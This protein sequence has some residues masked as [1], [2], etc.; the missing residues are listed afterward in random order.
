ME[1]SVLTVDDSMSIREAVRSVLE[2]LGCKILEAEDGEQGLAR[3][4]RE[5][6]DLVI[7]DLDMPNIDGIEFIKRVRCQDHLRDL[8][9]LMLTTVGQAERMRDGKSA[10]ASG[11]IVKPFNELQLELAVMKFF[12]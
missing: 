1:K 6:V 7:T 5:P 3:L 11:W 12:G 8:P 10:V 2:P 4:E 9:M